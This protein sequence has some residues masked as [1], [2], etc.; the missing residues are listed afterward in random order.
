MSA[1]H[2]LL[3]AALAA[4]WPAG[5]QEKLRIAAIVNDEVVSI[6]DLSMRTSLV[7]VSSRMADTAETRRR[8]APEVLRGLIDEK[9]KMQEAKRLNIKVS[10]QDIDSTLARIEKQ[11]NLPP[12]GLGQ[13]LARQ[14]VPK[15]VLVERIEAE[16]AW[17]KIVS[18]SLRSGIT[19]GEEEVDEVLARIRAN[20]GKPEQRVAEI[21]LP[22]D[23]P[24]REAE[25]RATAERIVRQL[26][27]KADFAQMASSFSQSASAAV[28]GDL[29][30]TRQGQLG[31][32]LDSALAAL[33]PGQVSAPIRTLAGYR[34]LML[35]ARRTAPGLDGA[36]ADATLDLQQLVFPLTENATPNA[37]AQRME[38][39][40]TTSRGVAGCS[41]MSRLAKALKS[42]LSGSLGKIKLS[43]LPDE[44][45]TVLKDLAVA[46]PSP[47]LRR[48][49][50]IV[51][52]M[53]CARE[54][55]P[56]PLDDRARIKNKL[57][58][59]R[60]DV[61]A[62]RHLRDLRRAAFVDVRL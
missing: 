31:K 11:N 17:A 35:Q 32:T 39:A 26:E 58:Q 8:M 7:L 48:G 60:L 46:T 40:R 61:A 45:R 25:V 56:K 9:V 59:E 21:F 15:P 14:G 44:F 57:L 29:G 27:A 33:R 47:P 13:F 37:V 34:I 53:V 18:K 38:M 16:I 36:E 49:N 55:G 28:G 10:R 3:L 1:L 22:I 6:Y 4:A 24:D 62:R 51:V 41:D 54:S 20:Q 12:G 23:D 19:I 50:A 52:L 30:W 2:G 43:Q 42:P 5:A